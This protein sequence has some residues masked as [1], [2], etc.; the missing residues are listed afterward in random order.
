MPF[1]PIDTK[2]IQLRPGAPSVSGVW[3]G[4]TWTITVEL[5]AKNVIDV[6]W[7]GKADRGTNE[8]LT[9]LA[10]AIAPHPGPFHLLHDMRNLAAYTWD[11]VGDHA[12]WSKNN[13]SKIG[14]IACITDSTIIR[15]A[16]ATVV[17]WQDVPVRVFSSREEGLNW[18]YGGLRP[19]KLYETKD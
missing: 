11:V 9:Y 4:E 14:R 17:T 10:K 16:V 2:V 3:E 18:L 13:A 7:V 12:T 6:R 19:Q 15:F 1:D 5:L 8:Y